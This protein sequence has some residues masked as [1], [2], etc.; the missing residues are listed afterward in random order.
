VFHF[1][2]EFSLKRRLIL[3]FVL[4]TGLSIL[5][6]SAAFLAFERSQI[7]ESLVR[8]IKTCAEIASNPLQA[9][10]DFDNMSS[11]SNTLSTFH[12]NEHIRAACVYKNG[13]V[14]AAY[15]ANYPSTSFPLNPPSHEYFEFKSD[16]LEFFHPINSGDRSV[17]TLFIRSDLE[18]ID[19]RLISAAQV[20]AGIAVLVFGLVLLASFVLQNQ[21]TKP[22]LLLSGEAR[23]ISQEKDYTIR[24]ER[25]QGGEIGVLTDSL[26]DMLT[27]IQGRDAQ[28]V[29]YQEHLEEQVA[30]RSEELLKANT[31]L[32][33]A[34]EKA[35]EANQA[36]STFL[37]NMSHELRTPLNAILLYSEL[38]ADEVQE[39]GMGELVPDLAKIQSA[40]KHLLSLIDDILDLSKIEAGRMS[41]YMEDCDLPLLLKDIETTIQPLI[42][43]N[44]NSLSIEVEPSIPRIHT[45]LRMLRQIIYNLLNNAAKFTE[46]GNISF[47][48]TTDETFVIFQIQD[49]GIGMTDE[50]VQR[51]FQE[52]TQADESTTRRFGGTGL[53]LALSRKLTS[54]L[55]GELTVVSEPGKGSTFTLRVPKSAHSRDSILNVLLETHPSAR[56]R[57]VLIID[58]DPAM[59]E[60]LS[61]MLIHEGFW[62]AIAQDGT[63]GLELA[64]TLHPDVITLDIMMPGL[65]GW[66]VLAQI[67]DDPELCHIPVV[68]LTMLDDRARGFA[69]GAAEYLCKPISRDKL[70]EV[71]GKLGLNPTD[72]PLLL[73]EDNPLTQDALSRMLEGE[74]WEVRT[75]RDGF[76]AMEH[77]Q[78]ELPSLVILDLMMPGMDGFQ[79]VEEMQRHDSLREIPVLVLTAKGLTQEDLD[80]LTGPPVQQVLQK[81]TCSKEDL[82]RAVR[83]L[84]LQSLLRGST[85]N[86]KEP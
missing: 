81:G 75:A 79:L 49:S 54:I 77:L 42:T 58:D 39:R 20:L 80:R 1:S 14:Y 69:L 30:Q 15:P 68:L 82:L 3:L 59:R 64:R 72:S 26:N 55:G 25:L 46:D 52:F 41:I 28:L 50:Q 10:L 5:T 38:L 27:Q 48:V 85:G 16:K 56:Q 47:K 70:V 23:K 17:G 53:G 84:A 61:R 18:E 44:R 62:A 7:R 8:T 11:A 60:G 45:D 21:V 22:I 76:Q 9:D 65:D 73:V 6:S 37:A 13:Q 57:K 29:D 43:K 67:K 36:K 78:L 4:I 63:E 51:I 34:K 19:A 35:E 12:S 2:Q 40:G 74:G 31:Q 32:L 86:K 83:T 71:L 24:L 33:L 66:Q